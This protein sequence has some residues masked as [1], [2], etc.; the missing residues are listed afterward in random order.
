MPARISTGLVAG[1]TNGRGGGAG[2]TATA[3]AGS[4]PEEPGQP[5]ADSHT[6]AHLGRGHASGLRHFQAQTGG[7]QEDVH[8]GA[9]RKETQHD[10]GAHKTR[11]KK[12]GVI[13]R[14][15][16][17]QRRHHGINSKINHYVHV[18]LSELTGAGSQRTEQRGVLQIVV[19]S[20]QL[21][22]S[23]CSTGQRTCKK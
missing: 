19:H 11:T 4:G 6:M 18:A 21:P 13:R 2:M 12:N 16:G 8:W 22:V 3:G 15:R 7:L 20:G 5:G 23:Q 10:G 14:G 17:S 9:C 1:T